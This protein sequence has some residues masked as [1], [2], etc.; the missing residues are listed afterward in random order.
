M[1][2]SWEVTRGNGGPVGEKVTVTQHWYLTEDRCR[3]V[4]EGH[5]DGRWLWASPGTE[6]L[7]ADALRYGALTEEP[8]PEPEVPV[9][10]VGETGPELVTAGEG[11]EVVQPQEKQA[12][13]AANKA[14]KKAPNKAA[15]DKTE[16][17]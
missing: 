7:R 14:V 10:L 8:E 15:A 1:A 17:K 11:A 4:E 9:E 12:P 3:V 6:V 16:D 5:P 13:K 2:M